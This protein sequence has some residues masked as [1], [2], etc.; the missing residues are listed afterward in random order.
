LQTQD[1][2]I[3]G[4]VAVQARAEFDPVAAAGRHTHP[5]EEIGRV[6]EGQLEL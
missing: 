4:K 1:V 6:L 2:S 3:P 5:D